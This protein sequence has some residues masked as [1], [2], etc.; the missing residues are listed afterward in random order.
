[1]ILSINFFSVTDSDNENNFLL[2]MNFI[3]YSIVAMAEGITALFIALK[4]FP[5][6]R[7]IGE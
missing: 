5:G 1:M 7:V 3:N 4:R 6:I 2:L